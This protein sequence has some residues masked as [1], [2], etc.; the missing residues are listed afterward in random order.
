MGELTRNHDWSKTAL[1]TADRW[2][3]SL[4]TILGIIL[5]S[6]FPMLLF[7]G[8]DLICFYNDAFRPS[9]GENGKHP[10]QGRKGHE[11]WAEIW[12]FIGPLINQVMNTGE[13]VFFQNQLVPF[14]RNGQ[15]EDI[16][17]TFSYSPAYGDSG[18]IN[19]VFVTC[20]ETTSAVLNQQKLQVSEA[21]YR[22]I[23]EQAPVAI[24]TM[25][26]EDLIIETAN[27]KVLEIL[28][29]PPSIIGQ[30][31]FQVLPELVGE[32]AETII[33]NVY[34]T[35]VSF[36]VS[37]FGALLRKNG[38][39]VQGYYTFSYL[40]LTENEVTT[41]ILQV[42]VEV[43]DQVVARQK[44]AESEAKLNALI[45]Q[46]PV[47]MALFVGSDLVIELANELMINYFGKGRSILGK[48]VR[49]VL[50]NP[51]DQF[52]LQLLDQVFTTGVAYEAKGAAAD[53]TIDGV[54]GR[55]YFDFSLKP[56]VN[57][58][59]EVY[60]ILET[61]VEVTAQV[62]A[63]Q[64]LEETE[65]GLRGAVEMAQLGTWSIDVAT[66]GLTY[67]D[68]MIEW[69]GNDPGAHDYNQVIPILLAEDQDR[70]AAAVAQALLPESDGIYE[71]TYT[72][73]HP[74]TGQKRV[75][76]AHG[77]TV[78][79]ASGKAIRLNGTARDITLQRELQTALEHEVQ[80]RTEELAT[81]NKELEANN[82]ELEEA[83]R[84]LLRSNDNLQTFAYVASHDLQ[85][86][87]RK[88]QQFGNLLTARQTSLSADELIYIER[89]QSAASRMATLI[90]DLLNFS[91]LST[92]RDATRLVPL[93]E[94]VDD[95]LNTLELVMDETKAEVKVDPLPTIQGD[96]SQLAQLFQ[97]LLGNALKFRRSDRTG[98]PVDPIIRITTEMVEGNE[99]PSGVKPTRTAKAYY[100]INVIDN[101]VGFDEK[102]L[103]RIFQVFQRLH[104]K[105]EFSGT[106]IG[107]AICERV[108]VN[109]GGAI[110]ASSQPG[111]GATFSIYLPV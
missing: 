90:R 11:M 65:A 15:I 52:A 22:L 98:V 23:F 76:H 95:V 26:G 101:G 20:T 74:K 13:P 72:V 41:G 16:Y 57:T 110:T 2:P 59:G 85:E 99:L 34:R 33:K 93:N 27:A 88:I 86:P 18:H 84:L 103:D 55:Y 32:P 6:A 49:Q 42:A 46:A 50:T 82:E 94:V 51:G 17:W 7:W 60:A 9:L 83:N 39:L 8:E 66:N 105:H 19:G 79:D 62:L 67:S 108:V 56:L 44:V 80:Q 48:P 35:G 73:I 28:D 4:K 58:A 38:K 107:L 12:D 37:E 47:A 91:H 10:G 71:Q 100:R 87:L 31:W 64:Q 97:N 111:Q 43:T 14:Y 109:H 53:L 75:L 24:G 36:T 104:G 25:R 102:Y 92:Q 30:P 1:G 81:A 40:P 89:M 45:E 63:R 106:G 5:H 54:F 77:K 70:L 21:R 69:F 78:F 68:R 29:K 61:A 3:Q 96:A